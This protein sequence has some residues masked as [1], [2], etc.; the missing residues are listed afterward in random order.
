MVFP[1]HR[2]LVATALLLAGCRSAG[3]TQPA[4]VMTGAV[5]LVIE[6]GRVVD[7]TG[8]PWYYGDLAIRAGRIVTVTP[9][10]GLRDASAAERVDARGQVVAPGFIDIQSHSRDALL[11]GDSRVVSKITQGITTE[12]MGEGATNAPQ[13]ERTGGTPRH[14]FRGRDGFARWLEAMGGRG[15][16]VNLGSFVGA[17]TVRT[18]AKG[19]AQGPATAA[20]LDTMRAVVRHAMEDGAFGIAS[21][22]IYPPGNYAGT[23]EL[24]EISRAMAPYGGVYISHMR[25]EADAWLPAIDEALRIGREAGVPVEIYH[26]KAGGQRNWHKTRI[27]IAKIDSAR[28]AGQDV[29]ANMYAYVAGGTGLS[30]CLPPWAAADGKLFDNLRDPTT[31][32]RI[33]Q[34]MDRVQDEWENLCQLA[35]PDGVLVLGL[36]KPANQPLAGKRLSEIA[37]HLGKEWQE[38]VMDL[39]IAEEQRI[40]TVYFMMSEENVAAKMQQPWMKFGTDAGGVDP[41]SAR[42]LVH[43]RAYGNYPRIL[44]R[45]VRER[46]VLTLEE[47]VRKM[48]SAVATRLSIG[49]RG[50][51]R[52][53][54]WADVV[55]FDP[56]TVSDHATF[57]RPH[58]LSTG[59]RDVYVNGIAVVRNGRPTGSKPGRIVRGPGWRGGQ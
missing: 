31:R 3:P 14:D 30:S 21:A 33:R 52:P 1:A 34:E 28:A 56:A 47:A 35:T 8:N 15:S 32:S 46:G 16:S 27:A 54:M 17:S 49:D 42:G 50:L 12:I 10:G 59:I 39:L 20:E 58:Q 37:R 23:D 36:L 22:L 24:I 11:D 51:L 26:L 4:P 18:Y 53:G 7:G 2:T 6:G 45:Y 55:I 44:G 25:S 5:D 48:S 43:P 57:E 19:M 13:N 41:D 9:P 40:G 38:A 29:Q